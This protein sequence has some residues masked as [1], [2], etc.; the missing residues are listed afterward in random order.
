MPIG[1]QL[2]TARP[3]QRLGWALGD[4]VELAACAQ[5]G[6]VVT[7]VAL[8]RGHEADAAA[9]V[10]G[11]VPGDERLYPVPR[12]FQTGEAAP[13]PCR[14][15]FQGAEQGFGVRVVIAGRVLFGRRGRLQ[16]L[17]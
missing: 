7:F 11:V 14:C 17:A 3:R 9:A 4:L 10:F 12:F 8:L 16:L 15:V 6:R 2:R 1:V 5:D 13:G